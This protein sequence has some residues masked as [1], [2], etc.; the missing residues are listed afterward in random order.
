MLTKNSWMKPCTW[1]A[2][3]I[4]KFMLCIG[5]WSSPF[6][7][8]TFL[9]MWYY[10]GC[11]TPAQQTLFQTAWFVEG[12]LTQTSIIHMIRTPKIPFIQSR[13]SLSLGIGSL[14][15]MGIGIA[16]PFS[17]LNTFLKMQALPAMYFPFLFGAI[18]TYALISQIAKLIYIRVFHTWLE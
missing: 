2:K 14:I 9:Y 7:I 3:S 15:V 6:D 5:P 17:P 18:F 4:V 11:Q 16:I 1:S 13:P 8:A 12:L 10:F